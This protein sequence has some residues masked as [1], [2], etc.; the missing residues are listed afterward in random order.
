[1]KLEADIAGAGMDDTR[2]GVSTTFRIV[3]GFQV[4]RASISNFSNVQSPKF[5]CKLKA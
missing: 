1:M 4:R 5:N 3:D 2:E